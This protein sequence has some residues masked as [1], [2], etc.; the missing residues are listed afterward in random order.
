MR[1]II[2]L[3]LAITFI[4]CSDFLEEN[5]KDRLTPVNF[6]QNTE[7]AESAV[8]A[9]W[10]NIFGLWGG[11]FFL[12]LDILSDYLEG[13]GSTSPMSNYQGLD[14]TN[15]NR[16]VGDWTSFYR[17]IR[18][19]NIAIENIE[20]MENID[21]SIKTH[22]ISEALFMRA[23]CYYYLVRL[24]GPV[25]LYL[26]L[27][28]EDLS[29]RPVDEVYQAIINDLR[30]AE[31]NLPST[32]IAYGRPTKWAAQVFLSEVYLTI[33]KFDLAKEKAKEVIDSGL[34][35][36]VDVEVAEDFDN[37]FGPDVN[38]SKEEI[39]YIK[40]NRQRGWGQPHK[41]LWPDDTF[42]PF[43]SYVVFARPNNF[44]QNWDKNDLRHQY[45]VYSTYINRNTG[46]LETLP[47]S[48]PILVSKYRDPNAS[49]T[50]GHG[51][52]APVWRYA[53][54]L[55]IY[56]EA[57]VMAD[58]QISSSAINSVNQIR[59]RAY[60]YP[61]AST[62][63][64]DF[65]IDGWTVESF[66]EAILMERAYELFVEGGKRWFDLKR[67]GVEYLKET[68]LKNDGKTV[69]D[70]HLLWPIPQTEIDTNPD[71]GQSDQ[72]PGY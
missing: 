58:N 39:F 2:L 11:T 9:I 47:Q 71:I 4:S 5:P 53:D 42:S 1:K 50:G 6:Y 44:H 35:E 33:G 8:F 26:N 29:R 61:V 25:P 49:S 30:E 60:G 59:R 68:I 46:E 70:I 10:D 55:L 7:D 43:G 13:R 69:L 16:V 15:I 21:E 52:D 31:S 37:V 41:Y 18:N 56:A 63:P 23:F 66:R 27:T 12:N 32:P 45:F 14:G 28:P 20:N 64:V 51:N 72:N 17:S 36:L 65:V 54:A 22:L 34:F 38:G 48:T 40:H 57:A 19:A 24:W 3:L 62:S 67:V